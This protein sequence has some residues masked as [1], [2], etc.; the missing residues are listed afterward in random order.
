M[1]ADEAGEGLFL[2]NLHCRLAG[3]RIDVLEG[4]N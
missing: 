3:N 4:R 1:E 2:R